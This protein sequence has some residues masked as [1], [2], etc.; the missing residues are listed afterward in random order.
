MKANME[1]ASQVKHRSPFESL[2]EALGHLKEVR[3]HARK[4]TDRLV[5]SEPEKDGGEGMPD[6]GGLIGTVEDAVDEIHRVSCQIM[7]DLN[8]V[9]RRL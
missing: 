1:T 7:D 4:V 5:G 2:Q 9:E 8:R 6:R 3:D